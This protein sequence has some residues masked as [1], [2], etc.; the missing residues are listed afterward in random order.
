LPN[1]NLVKTKIPGATPG[2]VSR[3]SFDDERALLAKIRYNHLPDIFT[4]VTYYSLQNHVR[5]TLTNIGQVKTDKLGREPQGVHDVFPVQ[6]NSD[7]IGAAQ[8]EQDFAV[9]AE[10]SP[11]AVGHPIAAQFMGATTIVCIRANRRR[12]ANRGGTA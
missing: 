9:C 3:S 6:A 10:K 4:G 7:K 8:I 12:R 1:P 5:T 2:I 11:N